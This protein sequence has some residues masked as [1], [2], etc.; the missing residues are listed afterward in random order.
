MK[1]GARVLI[2]EAWR[3]SKREQAVLKRIFRFT[4][5][6]RVMV[7]FTDQPPADVIRLRSSHFLTRSDETV[8][9][10]APRSSSAARAKSIVEGSRLFAAKR[11]ASAPTPL[12]SN[13]REK[14]S[15]SSRSIT[16]SMPTH[17]APRRV[18]L[19][20]PPGTSGPRTA[21]SKA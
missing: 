19:I 15:R 7:S 16:P 17:D 5:K 8:L 3:L 9:P 6:T 21:D 10:A 13:S 12:A 14:A 1:I 20:D 18:S 2:T 11:R 4:K